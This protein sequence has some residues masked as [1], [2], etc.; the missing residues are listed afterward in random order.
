MKGAGCGK[1][2]VADDT[3]VV[4]MLTPVFRQSTLFSRRICVEEERVMLDMSGIPREG[5]GAEDDAVGVTDS[6][7]E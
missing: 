2:R 6:G 3:T 1:G 4:V 5:L 7:W